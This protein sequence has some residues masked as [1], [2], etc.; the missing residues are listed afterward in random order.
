MFPPMAEEWLEQVR[1][2]RGWR[3]FQLQDFGR[4]K[5]EYGVT[6]VVL[7]QPAPPNL[8]CPYENAAVRVCRLN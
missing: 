8:Q 6:W 7:Q 3:E 4:L 1:T 2:Q 5:E